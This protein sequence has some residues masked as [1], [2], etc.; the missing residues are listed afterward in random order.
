[1]PTKKA[2]SPEERKIK[3]NEYMIA[4][5]HTNKEAINEKRLTKVICDVCYKQYA[6][7]HKSQHLKTQHHT[8]AVEFKHTNM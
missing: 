7:A 2:E 3:K 5:Y 6:I 1:M 4:Y 8:R